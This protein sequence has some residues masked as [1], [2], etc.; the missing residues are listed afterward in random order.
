MLSGLCIGGVAPGDHRWIRPIKAFGTILPGDLRLPE[1]R[2]MRPFDVVSL[3]LGKPRPEPPHAED[4][5]CDFVRPRPRLV[6]HVEGAERETLLRAALDPRPEE[7]W[8]RQ[9][10]SLT[11]FQPGDLTATFFHDD[12]SGKFEARLAWPGCGDERGFPV[13]DLR[14][15]AL[16]RA[17]LPQGGERHLTWAELQAGALPGAPSPAAAVYLAVGLSRAY[18][19]QFWPIVVGV[20]LVPDYEVTLDE[21]NL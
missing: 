11:L 15:R 21:R 18:Q 16:G 10:R 20:H 2:L 9:E 13:T 3:A 5:L 14:W 6:R 1:G 7:V 12:Y 17:L 4:V 8:E 19:A